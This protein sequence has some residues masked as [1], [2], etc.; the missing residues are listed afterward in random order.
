M[1]RESVCWVAGNGGFVSVSVS[2]SD[3][4]GDHVCGGL[5][6]EEV[7]D[8]CCGAGGLSAV[9]RLRS[10]FAL[11]VGS[12]SGIGKVGDRGASAGDVL[13]SVVYA[14]VD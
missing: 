2:V 6:V 5:S 3:G 7:S 8:S 4:N 9:L 10:V 12:G 1:G 13:E 14:V 11:V